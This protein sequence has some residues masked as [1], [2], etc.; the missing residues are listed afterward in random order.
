MSAILLHRYC[1]L[2]S[3]LFD[4]FAQNYSSGVLHLDASSLPLTCQ[5]K[6]TA[7]PEVY[8]QMATITN[9]IRYCHLQEN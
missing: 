1:Y 4:M 6:T 2:A 5:M 7:Y 3:R 8:I 9:L